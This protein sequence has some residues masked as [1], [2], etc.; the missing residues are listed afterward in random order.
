MKKMMA[1]VGLSAAI[2]LNMSGMVFAGE[3]NLKVNPAFGDVIDAL[4]NHYNEEDFDSVKITLKRSATIDNSITVY[5]KKG[6]SVPKVEANGNVDLSG[7][8]GNSTFIKN[9]EFL[10]WENGTWK[11]DGEGGI[12]IYQK[13]NECAH[14]I[15]A[16]TTMEDLESI[17]DIVYVARKDGVNFCIRKK[18]THDQWNA[19]Q[20]Y[21]SSLDGNEWTGDYG[22]ARNVNNIAV[23]SILAKYDFS[24]LNYSELGETIHNELREYF[25]N[26]I[27]NGDA[28]VVS[29]NSYG[30]SP[31]PF[32]LKSEYAYFGLE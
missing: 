5:Y 16:T 28:F 25:K 31:V 27:V 26:K 6:E 1:F 19:I 15:D 11:E 30:D 2:C 12:E 20:T 4:E 21:G 24:R 32:I 29:W 23:K 7:C 17:F 3:Q 18:G 13:L 22:V 10:F 8:A 9:H 14:G